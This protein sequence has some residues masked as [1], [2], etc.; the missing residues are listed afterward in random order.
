MIAAFATALMTLLSHWRRRPGQLLALIVGLMSATALWSGVQALNA[1]A[2]GSYAR[3]ANSF[4][5]GGLPMLTAADGGAMPEAAFGA[6]RR[7]GWKVSPLV[8]GWVEVSDR[9]LRVLGVDP[10]SLPLGMG[11][12]ALAPGGDGAGA[13]EPADFLRPPWRMLIAPETAAELGVAEGDAPAALPPAILS[14]MA[15]PGILLM[16]IGA[17]QAVLGH[18][19]RIDRL[20]IAARPEASDPSAVAGVPLIRRPAPPRADLDA[21]TESFHLNLTAFG[22]LSFLVGLFIVHAAIGLAFEQRLPL[23]RTLR[24]SGLSSRAL[25]AALGVELLGI[26]V[27]AGAAG[28]VAGY[29]VAGAL[30]P[31]VAATLRGLYGAEAPGALSLSPWWWAAGLGMTLAGAMAASGAA[32]WR[33]ARMPALAVAQP[34]AWRA[35]QTRALRRQRVA[36]LVVAAGAGLFWALAPGLLAGFGLMA[37]LMLAAALTLPSLLAL[38]LDFGARRARGAVSGW[39]W[40]DARQQIS[41][42]SLALMALLLALATN[43]GV[44]SMVQGFR[45]VFHDWLDHRLSADIY[46]RAADAGQGER[47]AIWLGDR[48]EVTAILPRW[49][50][51]GPVGGW[52]TEIHGFDDAPALRAAWPLLQSAP[53]PWPAAAAGDAALVSEQLARR[54]KLGVGDAV[55]VPT[56]TGDWPLTVAGV[57]A[58]YGNPKGQMLVANAALA[59]RWPGAERVRF[60]LHVRP[61]TAPGLMAALRDDFGLTDG[62]MIDQAAIKGQ[63]R[64]IFERTF[65]VTSALNALTLGVAGAA[66]LTALLTLGAARLPQ[67][68]PLW[69]MGLPRRHIAALELARTAALALMTAVFAVP[70]GI[71]LAWVLVAVV[72]PEAFGW[73]LPLRLYPG[74]WLR[75][76]G[77]AGLTAVLA[78]LP[79]AWRLAR[80]PPARL[81]ATFAGE[82]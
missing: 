76:A 50:A 23:M 20:L 16:D 79:A 56:P 54:L 47:L 22:M 72:N 41:G 39:A 70:L 12:D 48:G 38:A 28:L 2:R 36:A 45:G 59:A 7:A 9:R 80:T 8:E 82:R 17:A 44:G 53:D 64:A 67:T 33:A 75:L 6:L 32:I 81:L 63:S 3:A 58:D 4:S 5:G 13:A 14:P 43:V 61:G 65:T 68:A 57:Y 51:E 21:L 35:A 37:G 26:A 73:R 40:A 78:S 18:E 34:E 60:G 66:L 52:P 46:L 24:A 10:V 55:T 31:D 15:A 69:A 29:A 1:E 74:D 19:G 77:L 27:I 25:A 30:L 62:Q 11:L 71:A 42:L 49:T